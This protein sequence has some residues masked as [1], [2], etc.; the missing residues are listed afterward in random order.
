MSQDWGYFLIEFSLREALEEITTRVF[1]EVWLYYEHTLYIC[2]Y[3]SIIIFS[4]LNK[5]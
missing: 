4:N 1:E 5:V 3:Y 2:L